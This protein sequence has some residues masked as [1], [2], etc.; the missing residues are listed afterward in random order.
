MSMKIYPASTQKTAKWSG[1]LTTEL[2][3]YPEGSAYSERNFDFRL[4]TATV[5][6]ETSV[7]T[8][9]PHVQRTLMVLEL[10][11]IHI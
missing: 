3:I 8:P 2:F 11:L 9:L 4:S 10:S 6:I 1:G 5:E 7:F